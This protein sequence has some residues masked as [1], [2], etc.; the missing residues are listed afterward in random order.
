MNN[1]LIYFNSDLDENDYSQGESSSEIDPNG[2]LG[3]DL[4]NAMESTNLN[5]S[6]QSVE[7]FSD[8]NT[9]EERFD[10]SQPASSSQK[11]LDDQ[12]SKMRKNI[13]I[14]TFFKNKQRYHSVTD[15]IGLSSQETGLEGIHL[16]L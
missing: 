5:E 14:S 7:S 2:S 13:P 6:R 16:S 4:Y 12:I 9:G 3:S 11:N 8:D 10:Y 1:I 15:E